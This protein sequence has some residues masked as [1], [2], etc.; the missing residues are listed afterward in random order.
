[1]SRTAT[2]AQLGRHWRPR[3]RLAGFPKLALRRRS[4]EHPMVMFSVI[5][6]TAF[7]SMA[8]ATSSDQ[9]WASLVAPPKPTDDA[10]ATAK[11]DRLPKPETDHACQG[12]AW[13]AES[14]GCIGVIVRESGSG[15]PRTI[16]MV[17][18]AEPLTHTPNIF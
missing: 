16:R 5:V 18:S 1:M 15:K 4:S 7:L 9:T 3:G 11:T 10:A 2:A 12:Q 17:A 13:G 14:A 6:A 8:V